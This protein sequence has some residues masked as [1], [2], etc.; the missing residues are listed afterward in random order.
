MPTVRRPVVTTNST[1]L[2]PAKKTRSPSARA[3]TSKAKGKAWEKEVA[4]MISEVIGL[5]LEDVQNARSGIKE[6]DI[7]LSSEARRRFPYHIE[8]KDW[9]KAELRQWVNQM[10][11]DLKIHRDRGT[12]YKAGLVV[13]KL[14]GDRTPYALLRFDHLLKL[15][16]LLKG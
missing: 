1:S 13:F 3:K 5:P 10:E 12:H 9:K 14:F 4:G 6:S 11:R 7:Q 16:P 8:C 15:L 2:A